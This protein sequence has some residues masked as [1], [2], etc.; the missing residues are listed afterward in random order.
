MTPTREPAAYAEA[1]RALLV[2]LV[3]LGWLTLDDNTANGI[4]TVVGILLSWV[5]TY[6]VR[7]HVSPVQ[8]RPSVS[9]VE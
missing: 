4:A 8:A 9:S 2:I 7:A 3:G 6:V 1:V 5:L